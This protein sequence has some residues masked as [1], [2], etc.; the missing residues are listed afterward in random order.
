MHVLA[1]AERAEYSCAGSLLLRVFLLVLGGT[2]VA[3][4]LH[5]IKGRSKT[6]AR[7]TGSPAA[8]AYAPLTLSQQGA[9]KLEEVINLKSQVGKR[10]RASCPTLRQDQ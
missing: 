7:A 5:L 2:G 4:G 6:A 3:M 8:A 9:A 10:I 1:K